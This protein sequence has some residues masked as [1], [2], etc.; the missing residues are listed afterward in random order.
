MLEHYDNALIELAHAGRLRHLSPREKIDFSSND[1]LALSQATTI[2]KSLINALDQGIAMGSG[3]SRLLRGNHPE[4]ENL[5]HQAAVFFGSQQS[6]FLGSGY[7]ANFALLTT[8]PQR[9]DLIVYD[10]LIHA[11]CH[12][13]MR[14]G[15]ADREAARHNDVNDFD[16][17]I[18][19]WRNQG[20]KG[21]I[22]LVV[23]SLYS[24]DGD[25]APLAELVS[26]ADKHEAFVLIDEAHASGIYGPDGRGLGSPYEGRGNI[27]S[28]H[29]CGKA[30][31][32]L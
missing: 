28:T 21:R 13:G 12:E 8:L 15:R 14:A 27:I 32:V 11:S 10:E 2:R 18:K 23:E 31:G 17:K 5:E 9:G 24:M 6:I 7:I 29:T 30:L 26:L 1:Y 4:H 20:G 22:W 16:R 3:G 25:R 19:R